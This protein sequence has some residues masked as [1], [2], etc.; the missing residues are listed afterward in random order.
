M[1]NFRLIAMASLSLV[2]GTPAMAMHRHQAI[3]SKSPFEDALQYRYGSPYGARSFYP[4]EELSPDFN[5][6]SLPSWYDPVPPSAHG[7]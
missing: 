6:Q 2:L 5:G 3:Y 1:M 7:G 4:R